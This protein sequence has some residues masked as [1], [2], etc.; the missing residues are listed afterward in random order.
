MKNKNQIDELTNKIEKCS[1]EIENKIAYADKKLEDFRKQISGEILKICSNEYSQ[2]NKVGFINSSNNF[3][4]HMGISDVAA[5]KV[6]KNL[7][8]CFKSNEKGFGKVLHDIQNYKDQINTEIEVCLKI[9]EKT[10]NGKFKNECFLSCYNK[11]N[12]SFDLITKKLE[13]FNKENN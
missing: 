9:C 2:L 11:F 8:E 7:N 3:K 5:D 10:K 1:I 6:L 12:K 4:S 13:N